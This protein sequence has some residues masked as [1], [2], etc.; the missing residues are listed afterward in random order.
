VLFRD[1]GTLKY[2]DSFAISF[3]DLDM[4]ADGGRPPRGLGSSLFNCGCVKA[5]NKSIYVFLSKDIRAAKS[6]R[7]NMLVNYRRNA[8]IG[9]ATEDCP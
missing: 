8:P 3:L 6:I 1:D 9:V 5:F 2:L 7:R 4:H